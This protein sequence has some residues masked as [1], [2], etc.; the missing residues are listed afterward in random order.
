MVNTKPTPRTTL[1]VTMAMPTYE[2]LLAR[3][4]MDSSRM[5]QTFSDDHLRE[6]SS[7]LDKWERLAKFLG[8]PNTDIDCIKNQGD[9]E[10]QRPRMLECWKQRCGSAATYKAM[11]KALLQISRTDLA[12]KVIILRRSSQNIHKLENTT[13]QTLSH[14]KEYSLTAPTSPASSSGVESDSTYFTS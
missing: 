9:V 8:M 12:E 14:P 13:N 1:K 10:E 6:F 2:E 7:L 3:C 11:V 5:Y 4:D